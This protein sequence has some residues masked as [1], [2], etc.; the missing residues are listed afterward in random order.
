LFTAFLFSMALI[1]SIK[2]FSQ[3]FETLMPRLCALFTMSGAM[4][5]ETLVFPSLWADMHT[6]TP[7]LKPLRS[8]FKLARTL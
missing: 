4:L 3:A 6:P 5:I 7:Y 8:F 1:N 2:V